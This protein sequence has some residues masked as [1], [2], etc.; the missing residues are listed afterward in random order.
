MTKF[1]Q[2]H[3]YIFNVGKLF[4][5]YLTN[6]TI[7]IIKYLTDYLKNIKSALLLENKLKLESNK[8]S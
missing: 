7:L 3:F 8:V 1:L 5:K 4:R 6:E 2:I